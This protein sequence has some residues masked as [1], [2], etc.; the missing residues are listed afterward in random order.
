M[1]FN[2]GF[3]GLKP[4]HQILRTDNIRSLTFA[5]RVPTSSGAVA[6]ACV[7]GLQTSITHTFTHSLAY[8]LT[9]PPNNSSVLRN[10]TRMNWLWVNKFVC[11]AKK[12]NWKVSKYSVERMAD[13]SKRTCLGKL[14][15]TQDKKCTL[16]VITGEATL[17]ATFPLTQYENHSNSWKF[18]DAILKVYTLLSCI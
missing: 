15:T 17:F 5:V 11:N 16:R 12:L 7:A 3:K 13:R 2:S 9:H 1:G 18:R 10:N 8:T 6:A 4:G 14:A